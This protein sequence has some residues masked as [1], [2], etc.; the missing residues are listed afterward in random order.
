MRNENKHN[1]K[2]EY[3]Q[4]I[5]DT[6]RADAA[7]RPGFKQALFARLA[8]ERARQPS[9]KRP[10]FVFHL[11]TLKPLLAPVVAVLV[12]VAVL[13]GVFRGYDRGVPTAF[14][15]DNF[16]LEATAADAIGIEPD[17][18]FV[19]KSKEPI[20]ENAIREQLE[21]VPPVDYTLKKLSD[22]EW[23]IE[24]V[25]ELN[26][27]SVVSVRLNSFRTLEDGTLMPRPYAW[28]YQVKTPFRIT[29]TLPADRAN[30]V[31]LDTGIEITFSE[32][33]VQD[34]ASRATITPRLEG[35]WEH[36]RKTWVFVPKEL[37]PG[38][39]YTVAIR[40]DLGL[41]GSDETLGRDFAFRFETGTQDRS[42]YFSIDRFATFTPTQTP[43]FS[44]YTYGETAGRKLHTTV[45]Q[46]SST[47][48]F[49]RVL[50]QTTDLSWA[51]ETRI[52]G[53][54]DLGTLRRVAEFDPVTGKRFYQDSLAFPEPLAEG[55]YLAV[56]SFGDIER[57]TLVES[58][59]LAVHAVKAINQTLVWVIDTTTSAPRAGATVSDSSGGSARTDE[60]GRALL[61][62]NP[63]TSLFTVTDGTRTLIYPSEI[64]PWTLR[65]A[66]TISA[67]AWWKYL[68]AD[69][70]I[71]QPTDTVNVWGYLENRLEGT[72]P[73]EVTIQLLQN[74]GWDWITGESDD[75]IYASVTLP[76]TERG[77]FK[78]TLP[79]TDVLP[80]GYQLV[81]FVGDARIAERGIQIYQ[82]VKPAYS[83][84]V[85][86]SVDAVFAG[87][88]VDWTVKATFFDGTPVAGVPLI[89]VGDDGV[90]H[91]FSTNEAGAYTLRLT[92]TYYRGP[93]DWRSY[94]PRSWGLEVRPARPEEAEITV[95]AS[96]I[97]FG[98]SIDFELDG[99]VAG[100][101]GVV[102][103]DARR[104]EAVPSYWIEEY[105]KEKAPGQVVTIELTKTTYRRVEVGE[106]YDPIRKIV[107]KNYDYR[108]EETKLPPVTVITD[109]DGLAEYRFPYTDQHMA[110]YTALVSA[111][112]TQGRVARRN[113]WIAKYLYENFGA[114][115][116]R[117]DLV[118]SDERWK[119]RH[120][121]ERVNLHLE[122]TDGPLA[123]DPSRSYLYFEAHL[124]IG[125]SRVTT[126][127]TTSF[128]FG[129]SHVPNVAVHAVG[130]DGAFFR[131]AS[132]SIWYE[133]KDSALTVTV[134]PDKDTYRPG[135]EATLKVH[136]EHT[137]ERR[138]VSA[139]V[140][141]N[142]VDEAI[143][144]IAP[145]TVDPLG[146]LYGFVDE[147]IL[148]SGS[149]LEELR[150]LGG[151]EMGGG[152]GQARVNF[153][154]LALFETVVT[155]AAGNGSVRLTL[156]DNI[157]SWRVTVQA[158]EPENKRAGFVVGKIPVSL[159]FFVQPV[160]KPMY[161]V[162]DMPEILVSAYG[163]ALHPDTE[164]AYT[165]KIRETGYE[166]TARAAAVRDTA[167]PL[168]LL[169]AGTY[170]LEIQA[171]AGTLRD[172]VVRPVVFVD[173][174]L[175]KPVVT[176]EELISGK[177][178]SGAESGATY[179]TF[180]DAGVGI[181]YD[182]L[183]ALAWRY[184]DRLDERIARHV[185]PKLIKKVFGEDRFEPETMTLTDYW[186]GGGLRLLPYADPDLELTAKIAALNDQPFEGPQLVR[187]FEGVLNQR[188]A[189]GRPPP[190]RLG[191]A[192]ETYLG[193]APGG[194]PV[195]NT[196]EAAI[197]YFGLAS[198]GEPVLLE[199]QAMQSRTD[200][201][202]DTRLYLALARMELG[203]KEGARTLYRAL[204]AAYARQDRGLEWF[205]GK[206][207]DERVE[208]TALAAILAGGLAEPEHAAL[209]AYLETHTSSTNLL[210]LERL[211]EIEASVAE[212]PQTEAMI[213][214]SFGGKTETARLG[215]G[216]SLALL[217][218]PVA[219][220]NLNVVVREGRARVISSYQSPLVDLNAA[221]DERYGLVRTY[222]EAGGKLTHEFARGD[223]VKIEL[224]YRVPAE[225]PYGAEVTDVL[226]AGL[227]AI[228]QPAGALAAA[229]AYFDDYC[230]YWPPS[231]IEDQR[232]YFYVW[233]NPWCKA[234]PNTIIYYARVVTPG[235]YR[236]PPAFI[237][238]SRDPSAANHTPAVGEVVTIE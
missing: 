165:L 48:Q 235:T 97:T 93:E 151:A 42:V 49:A 3:E 69:R 175:R 109:T 100:N 167:I 12:L 138:P 39:V 78:G 171:V 80:G 29:A 38:T 115:S 145:E 53:L 59:S 79:I 142:L 108:Q 127:P 139:E 133:Q 148:W 162:H 41:A 32:S 16:T 81:A 117:F 226:P 13:V 217:V 22:R 25:G 30:N 75:E 191:E 65:R 88:P 192:V 187:Y 210:I 232:V 225:P 159:P 56:T 155:D 46:F 64:D 94:Y 190:G 152:G 174:F 204:R 220:R 154:D 172:T 96:V 169:G 61:P 182:D 149:S 218:G 85:V 8:S 71:Y 141:L 36:Y 82:Y 224:H 107:Y 52:G 110:S 18:A 150:M 161:L 121:G 178:V 14:A 166:Q 130:W 215:R 229:G 196:R 199:V 76:V 194:A 211:I 89:A 177:V 63:T 116:D 202:L 146:S 126:E 77:T 31:P 114:D 37:T 113:V 219:R 84:T 198:Q 212:L 1:P 67:T 184:G 143:Y 209:D 208:R 34:I 136:V 207:G 205:D 54:V 111:T 180:T 168:P 228:S 201:D 206:E 15:Q 99:R 86:P 47:D 156:P 163:T 129:E 72:R 188:N 164:V 227:A 27:N 66:G 179:V 9:M 102:K 213:E 87:T 23:R 160:M 62:A 134:T 118:E 90:A 105:G 223:V 4:L 233:D 44:Y 7:P 95:N 19:L 197:A 91:E 124:G 195:A 230:R 200:L 176:A 28:A 20:T 11:S 185:A 119:P 153:R 137:R 112:D 158:I 193:I 6:S 135:E 92:P 103:I 73:R 74:Y 214:Y 181:Y 237:R 98:P 5:R 40:G 83:L 26:P 186:S 70:P 2:Q 21:I 104:V 101:E 147:G 234:N 221:R 238:S 45:Y 43:T 128:V 35:R 33:E 183:V 157:T 50:N 236:A 173:S 60:G 231:R 24:L 122:G 58:S 222:R 10:S 123:V 57:W 144:A 51:S 132:T 68:Y 131:T 125:N 203:D 55:M 106:S 17:S 216:Q 140:N 189:P 170:H 120:V